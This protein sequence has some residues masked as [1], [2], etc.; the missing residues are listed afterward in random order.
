MLNFTL[1]EGWLWKRHQFYQAGS[2]DY[3]F[4]IESGIQGLAEWRIG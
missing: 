4:T 2:K 3:F 1:V